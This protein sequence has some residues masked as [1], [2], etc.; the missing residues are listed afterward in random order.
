MAITLQKTDTV[1]LATKDS[2]GNTQYAYVI[3]NKAGEVMWRKCKPVSV[4]FDSTQITSVGIIIDGEPSKHLTTPEII[5]VEAG[6][7][8]T[9]HPEQYAPGYEYNSGGGGY[10]LSNI[11]SLTQND[12]SPETMTL[13]AKASSSKYQITIYRA[14]R[15]YITSAILNY[16]LNGTAD[17]I[18]VTWNTAEIQKSIK[19]DAGTQVYYSNIT[20]ATGYTACYTSSDKFTPTQNYYQVPKLRVKPKVP[21]VTLTAEEDADRGAPYY[22]IRAVATN[23]NPTAVWCQM[24]TA[25][26]GTVS[27]T[28]LKSSS[29]NNVSNSTGDHNTYLVSDSLTSSSGNFT[30][31][32]KARF[33]MT[34][35]LGN[36]PTGADTDNFWGETAI[37]TVNA[38]HGSTST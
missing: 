5:Y 38:T 34:D 19:I 31:Q 11:Q 20:P 27:D 30:S 24:V 15:S 17:S 4:S 7:Q 1:Q 8:V 2:S 29:Y 13:T 10:D 6:T 32:A 25:P 3:K 28:Y 35:A 26:D 37:V 18:S 22:S 12:F 33:T 36:S 14:A 16:T 23:S 9:I 21:T